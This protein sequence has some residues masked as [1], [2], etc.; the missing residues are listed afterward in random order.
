M[1]LAD[2]REEP[3]ARA[4]D[5]KGFD[6]GQPELNAYLARFARQAHESG[7]A[8]TFVAVD[9]ADGVTVRAYYTLSPAQVAFSDV[10]AAA[11][12]SGA[13]RHPLGGFRLGR[14]AVAREFQGRGLGGQ[15]LVRAAQ[16]CLRASDHVGGTFLLIDAKDARAAAWYASYGA[17]ALPHLPLTLVLPFAVF[18][19]ALRRADDPAEG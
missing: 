18:A 5:R 8:K 19:E 4:H 15:L 11:R 10:P 3:V 14:L 6:C 9:A 2:W 17:L 12:P 13:G 16:R 1:T 7:A